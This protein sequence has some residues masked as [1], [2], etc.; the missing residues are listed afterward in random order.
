MAKRTIPELDFQLWLDSNRRNEFVTQMGAALRDIGFFALF[1]HGIPI[2]LIDS[3]YAISKRFFALDDAAK[4]CYEKIEIQRQRGFI[5]FGVEHAK[6]NPSP[7]L[8]E[9]WQTGRTLPTGH[10]KEGEFIANIWPDTDLPDFKA[11]IDELYREMESL[12]RELLAAASLDL[13]KPENWLPEMAG[14]GNT[15]LRILHY[16]PISPTTPEGAVRSAEHEDINFITLLVGSTADGLEVMDHDGT[17][18]KVAGNHEHIIV[19]SGDMIQNLSN[20]L[21]KS[22]THRVVNPKDCTSDRYSMPMFVHPHNDVD[23]SPLPEFIEQTGGTAKYQN[24]TAGDYLQQRLE[25]I[26]LTSK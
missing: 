21:Y 10:P 23:L 20:G 8:K 2:E 22:T 6:N 11:I 24:I 4:M 7:D 14:D 13:G 17:W 12:S 19:D 15:I 5:P 9:F 1:N 18:I 25:E 26:G 3:S 16:P